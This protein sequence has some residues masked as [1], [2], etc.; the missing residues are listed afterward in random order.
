MTRRSERGSRVVVVQGGIDLPEPM[1]DI[2]NGYIEV[3][4]TSTADLART[5]DA[6]HEPGLELERSESSES[7]SW[8]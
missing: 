4:G 7:E 3:L 2:W 1:T 5:T 6:I 8:D